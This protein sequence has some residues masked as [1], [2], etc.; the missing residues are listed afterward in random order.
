MCCIGS[1]ACFIL[2]ASYC[3]ASVV[4]QKT[5]KLGGVRKDSWLKMFLE[6]VLEDGIDN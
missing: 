5:I 3:D 4:L 2:F 6:T 1:E